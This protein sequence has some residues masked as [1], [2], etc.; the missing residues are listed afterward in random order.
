MTTDTQ[1]LHAPVIVDP[2]EGATVKNKVTV[3]GTAEPGAV[4]TIA[5]AGD[6]NQ[7]HLK[8]ITSKGGHWSGTFDQDLPKGVHKIQAR[9]THNGV[10]S[11]WSSVRTFTVI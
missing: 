9:Q 7:L 10:V 4:V 5:E 2:A 1:V 8:L 6:Q 11:P 3:A